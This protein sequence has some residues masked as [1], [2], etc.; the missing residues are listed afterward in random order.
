MRS[1]ATVR[2]WV[3]LALLVSAAVGLKAAASWFGWHFRKEAVALKAPLRLFDTRQLGPRY[4]LNKAF[5]DRLSP[6][7]EDMVESLG[8]SEY[9]Q[10]YITDTERR[11]DDGTRVASL[12]LTYYTGKPDMVPHVPD[13]CYLAG[14]Y[15]LVSRDTRAVPVAGVGAPQD[16]VPVRVLEFRGKQS[17]LEA[18]GA[19]LVSVLYFFHANGAYMTTRDDVRK[20]MSNP[21]QR[22]AYYAKIE[23]TFQSEI[24][25]RASREASVA[26]VGPLLE[27]VL[28]ALLKAHLDL[29]RFS[30]AGAAGGREQN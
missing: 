10:V 29:D 4:E 2:Y 14:G 7:S 19:D 13:E 30:S 3:C 22:Y 24:G 23:V 1:R 17:W 25:T 18:S 28:P 8:T 20:R 9:L 16:Q 27:R 26:A 12:F 11:P 5:T 21:F 15:D 6:M